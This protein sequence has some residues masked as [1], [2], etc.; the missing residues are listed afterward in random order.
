Y[1]VTVKVTSLGGRTDSKTFQ[2]AVSDPA[3]TASAVS[4]NAVEGLA[5]TNQVLA[6]FTDLAGAEPN[7]SDPTAAISSHYTAIINW[8]DGTASTM[9]TIILSGNTFTVRGDHTYG[10]EGS[11]RTSV[12]ITH[13]SSPALTVM[14]SALV[15]DPAVVASAVSF[16]AVEGMAFSNQPVAIF[17][18]PA[19][20]E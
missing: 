17:D 7:A 3:V 19:G 12:K 10:E 9:G 4:V 2:V 1:T 6:T 13:E 18:D 15:S 20:N 14:G 5:F 8:G 16:A 11:Y